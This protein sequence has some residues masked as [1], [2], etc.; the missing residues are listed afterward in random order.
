L[1]CFGWF[2]GKTA[3]F[4]LN[5]S[6]SLVQVG[7]A[8]ILENVGTAAMREQARKPH[9]GPWPS[10]RCEKRTNQRTTCNSAQT[11]S[12][13]SNNLRFWHTVQ[14]YFYNF[15]PKK[16]LASS[17]KQK[18]A[19]YLSGCVAY[20]EDWVLYLF[21]LT[22]RHFNYPLFTHHP[23]RVFPAADYHY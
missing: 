12:Q 9:H 18:N 20:I 4:N 10:Q 3:S 2:G 15:T 22:S 17:I 23:I 21:T 14:S 6:F 16:L 13:L 8:Q 7:A 5:A 19:A 1:F 11:T